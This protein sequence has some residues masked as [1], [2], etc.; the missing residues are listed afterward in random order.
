MTKAER[1]RQFIIEKTA[2]VFNRKG[3]AGT[4]LADITEATGLTKGSIYGNFENKD[5]VALAVFDHNFGLVSSLV[6]SKMAQQSNTVD[7]LKV[8]L[9]IYSEFAKLP[10]LQ[11]GC[12]V[13]N[14]SVESDDTHEEL[15]QKACDA[16]DAWYKTVLLIIKQG[17]EKKEIRNKFDEKEFAGAFIALIEGG[18]MLAKV[19]GKMSGLKAAMKQAEK[20][21]DAISK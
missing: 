9:S 20:M 12:P 18:V 21:I 3:Y 16:I 10:A 7:K 8:Y 15:R 11:A 19:T 17:R 14:T 4:S 13:L 6:H 1:T 2:P 5:E